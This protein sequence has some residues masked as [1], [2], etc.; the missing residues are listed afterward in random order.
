MKPEVFEIEGWE[1]E[2]D[3]GGGAGETI[4]QVVAG[5]GVGGDQGGVGEDE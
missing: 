1:S 2:G 4:D 3:A 5:A